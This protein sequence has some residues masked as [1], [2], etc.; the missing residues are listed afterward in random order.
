V[1]AQVTAVRPPPG[2][3]CRHSDTEEV[4][5][6]RSVHPGRADSHP[7]ASRPDHA[8]STT[9]RTRRPTTRYVHGFVH[10]TWRDAP[11]RGRH[12][13]LTRTLADRSARSARSPETARDVRAARRMAHN[14]E[15]VGSNPAPTT[16]F[17]RSRPFPFEERA[18]CVTGNVTKG[19]AGAV[20][21]GLSGETGW[22]AA[23]QRGTRQTTSPAISGRLAQGRSR[24]SGGPG[25]SLGA[26]PLRAG[27]GSGPNP[28]E[29]GGASSSS[30]RPSLCSASGARCATCHW[31]GPCAT[32]SA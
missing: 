3:E 1:Y 25:L 6:K 12:G 5:G 8:L 26:R 21:R 24:A 23:R 2:P 9:G 31:A 4:S 13:G 20:C 15:V 16:S 28:R 22:H 17:R 27:S 29:N 19:G 32:S 11:K 30:V 10:E 14:P 18:F 7:G